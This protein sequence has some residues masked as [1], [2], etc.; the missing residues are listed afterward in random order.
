MN[1]NTL[2]IN[3]WLPI[4][5]FVSKHPQFS[6]NQLRWMIRNSNS[7]GFAAVHTKIGRK[8]YICEESF[9]SYLAKCAK[10]NSRISQKVS[11]YET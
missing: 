6:E 3:N 5:T 8:I 2:K 4:N 7:N 10:N 9:C 1:T 11:N